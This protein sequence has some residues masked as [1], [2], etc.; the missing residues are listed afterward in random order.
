[1]L[2]VKAHGRSFDQIRIDIV[3][4]L[5]AEAGEFSIE[6]VKAVGG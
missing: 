2:W 3:G 1:V 5:R 6:H 4:I